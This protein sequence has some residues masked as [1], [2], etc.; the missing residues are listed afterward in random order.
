MVDFIKESW[1]D[2]FNLDLYRRVLE[3]KAKRENLL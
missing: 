1:W 2:N 3:A